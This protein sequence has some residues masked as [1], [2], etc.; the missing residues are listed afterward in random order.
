MS[1]PASKLTS[2]VPGRWT[3][4]HDGSL[5]VFLIGMRI[6]RIWRPD[7]WVP[8]FTAMPKMLEELSAD[9][10]SGLLG[11]RVLTGWR[12]PTLVQYWR[13]IADIYAYASDP[14]CAHRPAWAEFNR[15]ARRHPGVVGFWHETFEVS[16]AESVYA[17]VTPLGLLAATSGVPITRSTDRASARLRTTP[18]TPADQTSPGTGP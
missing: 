15:R 8:A 1:D 6:N 11:Y 13:S 5:A 7:V 10:D 9:P 17:D 18:G 3:H 12:G 4:D 16:R 2:I 14:N